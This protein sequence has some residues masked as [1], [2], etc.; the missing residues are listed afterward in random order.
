MMAEVARA[1][2]E[3]PMVAAESKTSALHET[4]PSKAVISVSM[5]SVLSDSTRTNSGS[6]PSK[7]AK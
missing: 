3:A 7:A 2:S 6:L 4:S 1:M 5:V